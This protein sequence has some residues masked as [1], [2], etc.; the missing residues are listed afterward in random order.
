MGKPLE[1]SFHGPVVFRLTPN[2]AFAYLAI[3]P[4]HQLN[5]RTDNDDLSPDENQTYR[6]TGPSSSATK[7]GRGADVVTLGWD[8]NWPSSTKDWLYI[9]ELPAPDFIFGLQ[10]EFIDIQGGAGATWKGKYARGVRFQY[11]D[12]PDPQFTG[13]PAINALYT[14]GKDSFYHIE[15]LYRDTNTISSEDPYEDAREC[16]VNMRRLLKPCDRWGVSFDPPQAS[17]AKNM[18]LRRQASTTPG[19]IG[20]TG[21]KHPVDCGSPALVLRDGVQL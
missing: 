17:V 10:P 1:I 12:S 3:C 9:F 2:S 8:T 4:Y 13:L 5:V 21:G 14:N 20:N 18:I 15:I 16:F 19:L 11:R 6:L 7:L